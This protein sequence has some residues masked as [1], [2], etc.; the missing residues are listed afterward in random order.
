M[1]APTRVLVLRSLAAAGLLAATWF[2]STCGGKVV[3]DGIAD[4][5]APVDC[6]NMPSDQQVQDLVGKDCAQDAAVC[7]SLSSCSSCSVTCTAGAWAATTP[8]QVCQTAGPT[9]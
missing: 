9:C 7:T 1:R 5:A 4:A 6:P 2:T 8:N 3:F